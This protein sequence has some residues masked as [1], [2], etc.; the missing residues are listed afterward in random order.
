MYNNSIEL[1]TA[2]KEA[3]ILGNKDN[4]KEV[5]L[6]LR[7]L[8]L[9]AFENSQVQSW[10]PNIDELKKTD[11]LPS[12]LSSFLSMV[13]T[14]RTSDLSEKQKHLTLSIGQDI[15]RAVTN[16]EWKHT[17]VYDLATPIQK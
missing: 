1:N 5:A 3:Y 16:S 4:E 8:V 15:C 6:S 17:A 14:G 11:I 10:P 9:E 13:F 2:I 12:Q 7:K